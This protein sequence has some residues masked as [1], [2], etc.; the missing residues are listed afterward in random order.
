MGKGSVRVRPTG[1]R[2]VDI[3]ELK[4]IRDVTW[5]SKSIINNPFFAQDFAGWYHLY[6]D[7]DT[8][9]PHTIKCVKFPADTYGQL[10]QFFPIPIAVD[11]IT[12]F[13]CWIRSKDDTGNCIRAFYWYT[14]G[15]TG[16]QNLATSSANT[17]EKK[18]LSPTAGKK[19]YALGFLGYVPSPTFDSYLD[20]IL[21]V[22]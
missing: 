20:T 6:V 13:A 19:F 12:E 2:I 10:M 21:T 14:D 1:V 11:W 18:T 8:T 9:T 22:F 4:K 15:T 7:I 3:E 5:S 16:E 17:W